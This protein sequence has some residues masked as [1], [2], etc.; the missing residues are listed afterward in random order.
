[1]I[2]KP[3]PSGK[4]GELQ[5]FTYPEGV[6]VSAEDPLRPGPAGRSTSP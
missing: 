2:S 4:P 6:P 5:S 3:D 1:M